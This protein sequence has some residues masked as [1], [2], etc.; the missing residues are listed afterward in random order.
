MAVTS[1]IDHYFGQAQERNRGV[2]GM[3]NARLIEKIVLHVIRIDENDLNYKAELVRELLDPH[4]FVEIGTGTNRTVFS[5]DGIIFKIALDI[6][7]LR[8]NWNEYKRSDEKPNRFAKTYETNYVIACAEYVN[9]MNLDQFRV[10]RDQILEFDRELDEVYIFFDLG[11]WDKNYMNF[12]Y[13]SKSNDLVD[14]KDD[15]SLVGCDYGYCYPKRGQ[16]HAFICPKCNG[17]LKM[18]PTYVKYKCNNNSCGVEYEVL[19]VYSRFN[20]DLSNYEDAIFN[21]LDN[22]KLINIWDMHK[23]IKG[24]RK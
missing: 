23:Y 19:E 11:F 13:R 24:Y 17:L 2:G 21:M 20:L 12:A 6:P 10:N 9:V 15:A 3:V 18:N 1:L 16:E 5:K 14:D 7:G 8:D 22:I 4:G